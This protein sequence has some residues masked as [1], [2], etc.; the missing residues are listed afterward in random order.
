MNR[1]IL[2]IREFSFEIKFVKGKENVVADQLFRPFL[3]TQVIAS[4]VSL[5]KYDFSECQRKWS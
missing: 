5:S 2:T 1:W 4:K 3:R